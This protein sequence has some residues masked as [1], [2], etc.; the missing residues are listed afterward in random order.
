ML[1]LPCVHSVGMNL[2]FQFSWVC[3]ACM[4][5]IAGLLGTLTFGGT[6]EPY[7]RATEPSPFPPSICKTP[8]SEEVDSDTVMG[9]D[10]RKV[11]SAS[12]WN[13]SCWVQME[14]S[15][16][17]RTQ[18][19]SFYLRVNICLCFKFIS[20]KRSFFPVIFSILSM[21]LFFWVFAFL[22]SACSIS[23]LTL[24]PVTCVFPLVSR[25]FVTTPHG[26]RV[27]LSSVHAG[28]SHRR[29]SS[30]WLWPSGDIT[31]REGPWT[32]GLSSAFDG[33]FTVISLW[34]SLFLPIIGLVL[35]LNPGLR[36]GP[37]AW[38]TSHCGSQFFYPLKAHPKLT[39]QTKEPVCSSRDCL[40][41]SVT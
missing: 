37:A 6:V 18:K 32:G 35:R 23:T 33:G 41:R 25:P 34:A 39:L 10:D 30:G 24:P 11:S 19:C 5:G 7:P 2:S 15:L 38:F 31:L 1:L 17:W 21:R 26:V 27:G 9:S 12:L 3:M 20:K 8:F 28:R 36:R 29:D 4:S 14:S 22:T 13:L 40:H 16:W